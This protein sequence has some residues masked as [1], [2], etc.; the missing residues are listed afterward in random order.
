MDDEEVIQRI[1]ALAAEEH[2]LFGREA[3]GR[4]TPAEIARLHDLQQTLDRLWEVLRRVRAR[5][6]F[7]DT[8]PGA[9]SPP[10][11]TGA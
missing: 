1:N 4:A 6:D 5:R 2:E 8:L 10:S 11:T 7:A 9:A 3:E